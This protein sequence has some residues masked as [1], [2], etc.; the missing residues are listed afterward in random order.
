MPVI[1]GKPKKQNTYIFPPNSKGFLLRNKAMGS[2]NRNIISLMLIVPN[3]ITPNKSDNKI[4]RAGIFLTT[5]SKNSCL[6]NAT[7]FL[8]ILF[9]LLAN[10]SFLYEMLNLSPVE[11]KLSSLSSSASPFDKFLFLTYIP[12]LL[13]S[14]NPTSF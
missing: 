9:N 8:A 14:R 12:G 10:S 4:K 7:T 1:P 5:F 6:E 11:S 13:G 3:R 2:V